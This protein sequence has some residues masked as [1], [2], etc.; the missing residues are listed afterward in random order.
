VP[1]GSAELVA[2]KHEALLAGY[3]R[4]ERLPLLLLAR[5]AP[6]RKSGHGGAPGAGPGQVAVA[7]GEGRG[8]ERGGGK[9][10]GHCVGR[11]LDG[12]QDVV[13]EGVLDSV[14]CRGHFSSLRVRARGGEVRELKW[15]RG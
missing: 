1:Y 5:L 10:R 15:I 8:E 9:G 11:E 13:S 6:Y 14:G 12:D 7:A 4:L 3:E 2:L